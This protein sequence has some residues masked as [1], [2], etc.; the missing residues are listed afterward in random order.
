[1]GSRP[2]LQFRQTVCAVETKDVFAARH[3]HFAHVLTQF[4]FGQ[5][6]Y[7]HH[8]VHAAQRGLPLASN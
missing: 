8:F 5:A 4:Y 6:V 2:K 1:M 7:L 3:R